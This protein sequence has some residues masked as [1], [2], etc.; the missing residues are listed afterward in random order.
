MASELT[1]DY[2]VTNAVK[3]VMTVSDHINHNI[4][5]LIEQENGFGSMRFRHMMSIQ[6]EIMLKVTELQSMVQSNYFTK[7]VSHVM[8]TMQ[9]CRVLINK[10]KLWMEDINDKGSFL[11]CIRLTDEVLDELHDMLSLCINEDRDH[12]IE[13]NTDDLP[14]KYTPRE[15][16]T[17]HKEGNSN[18]YQSRL[19][20]LGKYRHLGVYENYELAC[21]S[22]LLF[23]RLLNENQVPKSIDK[24]DEMCNNNKYETLVMQFVTMVRNTCPTK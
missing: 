1:L 6:D 12:F 5:N 17:M 20:A 2:F 21:F 13:N 15:I 10:A 22:R 7:F 9:D 8:Y 24:E 4:V 18:T 23:C 14:Y 16:S 19:W 3:N 11:E